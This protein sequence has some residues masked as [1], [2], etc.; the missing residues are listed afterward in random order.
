MEAYRWKTAVVTLSDKGYHGE[1]EDKSGPLIQEIVSVEGYDIVETVLLP[2]EQDRIEQELIRLSDEA[3]MD[4]IFTTGGTGFAERD[5]TPEATLHVGERN[6]PGIADAIRY[7]SLQVTPRAMLGR[8]VSVIRGKTLIVNLP[9][10]PKAVRESLGFI[11]PSLGHGL[12]VL[13]GK[14]AECGRP[15]PL[16]RKACTRK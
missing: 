15:D 1:R 3:H 7:Y 9:G 11:L 12:A 14:E 4:L 13:T 5:R 2:D 16:H 6:A 8:G 10:S